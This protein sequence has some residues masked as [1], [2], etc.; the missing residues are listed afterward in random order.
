MT[1]R[2]DI[3]A[4][5][6]WGLAN[7]THFDYSEGDNRWEWRHSEVFPITTDCSGFAT[8]CYFRA[9]AL[10]PNG[11]GFNGGYTGTM[12]SHGKE[13]AKPERGD[14]VI[15]FDGPGFEPST[16]SHVAVIVQVEQEVL[17]ISHGEQGNPTYCWVGQAPK[18]DERHFPVDTRAHKFF[19]WYP[20]ELLPK[21][22]SEPVSPIPAPEPLGVTDSPSQEI[23]AQEQTLEKVD[24]LEAPQ[25]LVSDEHSVMGK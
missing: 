5:A 4:Q 20:P 7:R 16:G 9:K 12:I 3:V 19:T 11:N 2:D 23:S 18:N 25:E 14:L 1:I 6:E 10:D 8:L 24:A 21:P 17:T 13:T 22:V 15:Y